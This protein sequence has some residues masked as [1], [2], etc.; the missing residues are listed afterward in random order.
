MRRSI[1][2]IVIFLLSFFC[3][4]T[5]AQEVWLNTKSGVYHCPGTQWFANTKNGKLIKE[6]DARISGFRPAYGRRCQ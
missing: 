1:K 3:F 6:S 4:N 2:F 5:N